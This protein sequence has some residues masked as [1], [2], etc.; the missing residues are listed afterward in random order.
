MSKC[1]SRLANK[2]I[3]IKLVSSEFC[4][5][6]TLL[7]Y[8]QVSVFVTQKGV[9][10]WFKTSKTPLSAKKTKMY[11]RTCMRTMNITKNDNHDIYLDGCKYST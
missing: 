3:H 11:L 1:T 2:R 5:Q 10:D 8:S 6:M 9:S 4:S 7:F